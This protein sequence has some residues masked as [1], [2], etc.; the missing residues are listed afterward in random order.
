MTFVGHFEV[1]QIVFL[2]GQT[3]SLPHPI[4]LPRRCERIWMEPFLRQQRISNIRWFDS[5][6]EACEGHHSEVAD[7]RHYK[8]VMKYSTE[9]LDGLLNAT[10]EILQR[11]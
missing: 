1:T 11:K 5:L 7:C 10:D 6:I 8:G 9:V 4:G 2:P 3:P